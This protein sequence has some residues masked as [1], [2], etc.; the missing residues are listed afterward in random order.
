MKTIREFLQ[1][2]KTWLTALGAVVASITAYANGGIDEAALSAAIVASL[3][4]CF[5]GA[6]IDRAAK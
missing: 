1:G 5:L 6:K 2:K 4:A 3:M